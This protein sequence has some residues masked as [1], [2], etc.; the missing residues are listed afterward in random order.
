MSKPLIF[1][2]EY[3]QKSAVKQSIEKPVLLN[4]VHLSTIYGNSDQLLLSQG[5]EFGYSE[6]A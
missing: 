2:L 6:S 4:L 5:S 3:C 1:V